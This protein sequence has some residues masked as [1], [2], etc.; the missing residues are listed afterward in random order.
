MARRKNENGEE[1]E[2][3]WEVFH[4]NYKNVPGFKAA[5]KLGL[6]FI[7]IFI[8]VVIVAFTNYSKKE[9]KI[10]KVAAGKATTTT[11][12]KAL[13]YGDMLEKLKDVGTEYKALIK[14]NNKEYLITTIIKNDY[15]EGFYET[16]NTN[17]KFKL[18]NDKVI[19]VKMN[20]EI[21]N[22]SLLELFDLDFI[23]PLSLINLLKNTSSTKK[24]VDGNIVYNYDINKSD[25]D[26]YTADVTT[27]NNHIS[28]IVIKND[29]IDYEISIN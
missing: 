18:Q 20:N 19:E 25:M 4:R 6:Y 3:K 28:K 17:T 27:D 5:V 16:S 10:E 2:T 23:N 11:S 13:S 21:E 8:L 24:L 29:I 14:M 15:I 7:F 12:I 22:A 26:S 1:L 9:K